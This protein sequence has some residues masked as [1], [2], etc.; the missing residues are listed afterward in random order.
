MVNIAMRDKEMA[1][2]M[3]PCMIY[4]ALTEA[5]YPFL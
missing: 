4:V 2:G 3:L 1:G 5:G